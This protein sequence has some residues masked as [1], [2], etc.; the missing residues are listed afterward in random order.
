MKCFLTLLLTFLLVFPGASADPLSPAEDLAETVTVFYNGV[1]DSDGRY[2][3]SYRY[4]CIA[5]SEDLSA[6]C[7]NEYYGKRIREYLDFYIPSQAKEYGSHF[8]NAD[9]E[10]SYDITCN[11]DD[12]FS[13]LIL[14]TE[15]VG[16]TVSEILEGNTFSRSS[17]RIGSLTSIPML[18]GILDASESDEWLMDRQY[19]KV[20]EAICTLVW[21]AIRKNPE[22]IAYRPDLTKED[23]ERI[24]D[25]VISL[26]QDFYMDE[27]GNLVFFILPGRAAPADAGLLT[28]P[29]TIGEIL[30][31]L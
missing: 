6:L 27:A 26:E 29:F 10:V 11:N 30:D 9:I 1:D 2:V 28:F 3:Y 4:P 8:Q 31:E 21:D 24:I 7:I 12:F 14:K 5:D 16:D 25:P 17:E 13:V 15:K 23:L 18:L 22:G 19:Q 20:W